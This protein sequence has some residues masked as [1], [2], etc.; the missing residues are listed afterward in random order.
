MS[1]GGGRF[2]G[3]GREDGIAGQQAALGAIEVDAG[4]GA[5]ARDEAWGVDRVIGR[6]IGRLIGLLIGRGRGGFGLFRVLAMK[7]FIVRVIAGDG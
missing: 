3:E 2:G 1:V 5:G 6:L 7:F 4:G